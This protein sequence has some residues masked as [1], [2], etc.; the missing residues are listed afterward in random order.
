MKIV[1]FIDKWDSGGIETYLLSNLERIERG[2]FEFTI[3]T[4]KKLTTVYDQRLKKINIKIVE[5]LKKEYSPVV[6]NFKLVGAFRKYIRNANVDI[7]HFHIYN[8]ISMIY[9]FFSKDRVNTRIL[10]SHNSDIEPGRL[11]ELKILV[12]KVCRKIFLKYSTHRWACSDLAGK[13]LYGNT[14]FE[15][16]KN[17]IS[18]ENFSFDITKR[19]DFRASNSLEEEI[20][21][22]TI[23]RMN[24]QKNQI[25]LLKLMKI[26]KDNNLL[27]RLY[28]V[29]DGPLKGELQE[30]IKN[31]NLNNVVLYGITNDIQEFLS[32]IDIFLLPSFFEGNPVSAIEAQTSGVKTMLSNKITKY[33]HILENTEF[34]DITEEKEWYK[35][36]SEFRLINNNIRKKSSSIVRNAGYSIEDTAKDLEI[37]YLK[38]GGGN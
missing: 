26:F 22:G 10:H 37:S 4:S 16:K 21:L 24:S 18:V 23:G 12:H 28:I 19:N 2:K 5:L 14:D 35:S 34:I 1:L 15:Y 13:W 29:G 32:G 38:L 6:R 20:V 8:A 7:I 17:G 30:F 36:I 3:V 9:C 27:F 33:A 11:R 25:F 31:N